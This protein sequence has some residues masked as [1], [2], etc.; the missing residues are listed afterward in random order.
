MIYNKILAEKQRLEKRIVDLQSQIKDLPKGKLICA[1]NGKWF[2][3]IRVMG[4]GP[5]TIP[6][7]ARVQYKTGYEGC[8]FISSYPV[9]NSYPLKISENPTDF[10]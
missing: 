9:F 1:S 2:N 7:R 5:H 6:K 10:L 4:T 3:G 8:L